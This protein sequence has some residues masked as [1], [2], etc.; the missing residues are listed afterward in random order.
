MLPMKQIRSLGAGGDQ[1][2]LSFTQRPRLQ[3]T[4]RRPT[5]PAFKTP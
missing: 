1:Q 2:I 5:G 4:T 3:S